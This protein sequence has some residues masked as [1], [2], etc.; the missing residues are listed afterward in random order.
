MRSITLPL[1]GLFVLGSCQM[2][3][4][5]EPCKEF[6]VLAIE[7]D[8]IY[9]KTLTDYRGDQLLVKR[10]Q[11]SQ[12]KWIGYR[13]SYI[14]SLYT[15]H[16]SNY[17]DTHKD[18]RCTELNN[19]QRFRIDQLKKWLDESCDNSKCLDSRNSLRDEGF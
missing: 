5:L 18:C 17:G 13:N 3:A 1:I 19:M 12:V 10:I 16:E 15:D 14:N 8:S 7:M 6:D 2:K 4:Q 11:A 9:K